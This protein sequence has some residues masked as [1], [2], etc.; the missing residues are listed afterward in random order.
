MWL[1]LAIVGALLRGPCGTAL[2]LDSN[3]RCDVVDA[4]LAAIKANPQG[5]FV[6]TLSTIPWVQADWP[7]G[8]PGET[9]VICTELYITVQSAGMPTAAGYQAMCSTKLGQ[10][11]YL[12]DLEW[13]NWYAMQ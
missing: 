3:A 6:R 8:T 11:T 12:S 10:D 7:S 1:V 13:R 5:R 2:D 9:K 4:Q